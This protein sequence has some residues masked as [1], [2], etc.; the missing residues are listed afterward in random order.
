MQHLAQVAKSKGVAIESLLDLP[1]IPPEFEHL[2]D[3]YLELYSGQVGRVTF[4]ELKNWSELML[5]SLTTE[6]VTILRSIDEERILVANKEN[7]RKN[8]KSP[9]PGRQR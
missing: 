1:S 7:A 6:E 5:V 9:G 4:T 3:W 2:W 8:N